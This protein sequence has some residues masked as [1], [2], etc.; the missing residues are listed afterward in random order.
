MHKIGNE[1]VHTGEPVEDEE[2]HGH[3]INDAPIERL[4]VVGLQIGK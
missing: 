3:V 1:V 4:Y 2:K